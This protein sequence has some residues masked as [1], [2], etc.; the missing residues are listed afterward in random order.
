MPLP[1]ETSRQIGAVDS[2]KQNSPFS[3]V[4]SS[5]G[6]EFPNSSEIITSSN[7]RLSHYP[8]GASDEI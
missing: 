8:E 3:N 6:K 7:V 4:M 2:L 1:G 5:E